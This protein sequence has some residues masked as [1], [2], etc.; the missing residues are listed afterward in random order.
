MS[1][2]DDHEL[3]ELQKSPTPKTIKVT[4]G[5]QSWMFLFF[6]FAGLSEM[7]QYSIEKSSQQNIE[8]LERDL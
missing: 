6:L 4:F 7:L 8:R 3:Q 5:W 1:M 2:S